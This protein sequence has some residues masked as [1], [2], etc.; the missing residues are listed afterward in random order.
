MTNSYSLE[1]LVAEDHLDGPFIVAGDGAYLIGLQD[2]SFPDIG[3]HEKGEMGG[4]W[5]HPIK[6]LDGFW[7]RVGHA[8]LTGATSFRVG[9]FW[10]EHVYEL[11]GLRVVRHEFVPDGEPVV[12]VR[13]ALTA[14]EAGT[15]PVRLLARTDLRDVW[16]PA[17][18]EKEDAPDVAWYR[19]DL[20][21]WVCRNE[22]RDWHVVVGPR[23][24]TPTE[25]ATGRDM[26]GPEITAGHGISVALDYEVAMRPGEPVELEFVIAGSEQ[27]ADAALDSYLRVSRR[28][29]DMRLD[30]E[31]RFRDMLTRSSLRVPDPSI[32]R[33]WD[34]LKCNY[35]W[36]VRA[37]QPWGRGLG[38]GVA[39]YP[40]WFGCDNGYAL[41]GCLTLGQFDIA[42]DTLDL[43]RRVSEAA[44][45]D[46]GRVIH[47]ANTR[48]FATDLG[49]TEETPHF[50]RA[51]WDTFLWTGD[52]TFVERNYDFCKRGLLDWT[53][54]TQS[55]GGDV[56]PHG[57]GVME[58]YG[59]NVQCVDTAS[60]TVEAL[61][62]LAGMAEALGDTEVAERCRG[63]ADLART[64]MEETFWMESEGLYGDM[65]ATPAEMAPRLEHWLEESRDTAASDVFRRLQE[66]A[67]SGPDQERKRPW[68]LK[69]WSVLCPLESGL[70]PRDRA[71]RTLD[72]AEGPEFTGPWGI[73]ICGTYQSAMMSIGTGVMAAAEAE[74]GRPE[75]ALRYMRML[76]DT[77]LM[78]S[79]GTIAEMS[80]DYGCFVQA[81]SG[82]AI[83]WPVVAGIFGV[84]PNAAQRR[85]EL[86]PNFPATWP[87][88]RL[89]NLRVGTNSLDLRWDGTTLQ[90]V[91][92]EDGWDIRC[93][94]VPVRLEQHS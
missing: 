88:A 79:P 87:D 35:D 24:R 9:P 49:R 31:Q 2:G 33:A 75:Q 34:W 36:L 60:L 26:W 73:Y 4:L 94:R 55:P 78:Q 45:G 72:R 48:G 56:L 21:A 65:V 11:D 64:R 62:G 10:A 37:V 63:L 74:Y 43:L 30:K 15:I 52:L 91:S 19:S 77:L 80:P 28:L 57:Y 70:A 1:P 5:A 67:R 23:G 93:A 3:W 29:P 22:T 85:I 27:G 14:A 86:A 59:L 76:T 16:S 69:N 89:S 66:E 81:W 84:K 47:E 92:R 8:W 68:L 46:S 39:D 25:H 7:L 6:L 83:A 90:V 18:G 41:R 58:M 20:P 13:Y 38:A 50:V 82:Y 12:V 32:M 42:I 17:P 40:W 44:N 53:L 71:L 61:V 51:V 54:G